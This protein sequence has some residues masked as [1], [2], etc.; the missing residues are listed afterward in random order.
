[1]NAP[2]LSALV[3][4]HN[5]AAQ[6]AD[7]LERLRPADELVVVL[8]RCTDASREIAARFTDRLIQGAWEIEGDRRNTGLDACTG[9]WILEIDAD[10]RVPPA[11]FAE[12]RRRI[13]GAEPGYFLV[14]FHNYVGGRLVRHGWGASWGVRATERLHAR[15][16]KRW[17]PQRVHPKVTLSGK[18]GWLTTPIDH[19]VDDDVA[20]M[21]RR[22]QRYTDARAADLRASG[23]RL[24][25]FLWTVRSSLSRF[26]KCFVLRRGWR[27]G[28]M[29]FAIALMAA[30]MPLIT[31]LKVDLDSQREP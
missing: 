20:D 24:P 29:G 30:L 19:L 10:E 13:I 23:A 6:L 2:R 11:L 27:E 31:R 21:V 9:D 7:C 28:R 3:V 16:C 15:G 8:D 26:F 25:P 17:G 18:A 14:P 5:E 12:I 4:A 22:L 1:M